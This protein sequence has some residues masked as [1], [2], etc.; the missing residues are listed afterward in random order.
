M[1]DV[2]VITPDQ[3]RRVLALVARFE[4]N[5]DGKQDET[6]LEPPGIPVLNRSGEVVPAFAFMQMFAT[7]EAA[8]Q[9]YIEVKKP[10]NAAILRC[11]M[12]INGPMAIENNGF[13]RAQVGPVFRLKCETIPVLGDRMG[14][15]DNEWLGFLGSM[16]AVIGA[17]D[18]APDVFKVMF[19]TSVWRGRTNV[20]GLNVGTP[21]LVKVYNAN[22]T[23]RTTEY[24]A[25]TYVSNI[26]GN[27]DILLLPQYGRWLALGMC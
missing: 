8:D 5:R 10:G 21:A 6:V 13:G 3:M 24:M 1:A 20:G 9:N 23:L 4:Q 18:V 14:P 2:G 25:E 19:D 27:T 15:T 26:A 17:D 16:Y 11:P 7:V 12:L 22:N